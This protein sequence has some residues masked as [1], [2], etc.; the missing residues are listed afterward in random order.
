MKKVV[1]QPVQN[2]PFI[3]APSHCPFKV[4]DF[5]RGIWEDIVNAALCSLC[6]KC[7][8][9]ADEEQLK[10]L[11]EKYASYLTL[12]NEEAYKLITKQSNYLINQNRIPLAIFISADLFEM[13]I[14][15]VHREDTPECRQRVRSH[16]INSQSPICFVMGA[17]VYWNLRLTL[18]Q[19]QVVGEVKWQ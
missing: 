6:K 17:P 19:I 3:V 14:S 18:S 2:G 11:P 9:I 5:H 15:M 8:F 12:L 4:S 16:F 13:M 10:L 7:D 1:L